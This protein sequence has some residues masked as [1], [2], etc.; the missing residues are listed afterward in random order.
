[1]TSTFRLFSVTFVVSVFFAACASHTQGQTTQIFRVRTFVAPAYPAAA[2][3]ARVQGKVDV[4]MQINADG[5][6]MSV[7][8]KS[9]PLF[10][11]YVEEALKQWRFEPLAEPA[12]LH[13]IVNFEMEGC[14]HVKP[15]PLGEA[16]VHETRVRADLPGTVHVSTCS[17]FITTTNSDSVSR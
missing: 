14:D 16:Q 1:M 12:L 15:D 8:V 10:Q 13:V 6:V 17:N 5:A 7:A 3:M 9:H 2:R 11:R 4:D